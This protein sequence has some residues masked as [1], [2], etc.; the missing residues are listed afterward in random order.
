M[1]TAGNGEEGACVLSLKVMLTGI[2]V[3][4]EG[5]V[6][7]NPV[8]VCFRACALEEHDSKLSESFLPLR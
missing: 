4:S 6:H 8:L 7:G 3:A 5:T 2:L 1:K